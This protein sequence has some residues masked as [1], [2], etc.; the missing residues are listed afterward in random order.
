MLLPCAGGAWSVLRGAGG[1]R[2]FDPDALEAYRADPELQWTPGEALDPTGWERFLAWLQEVL[3]A[4]LGN[5]ASAWVIQHLWVIV[6]VAAVVFLL[7][8]LRGS[9]FVKAIV[10]PPKHAGEVATL[11]EDVAVE[12]I[13]ALIREAEARGEWRRA[14]RLHYLFVLRDLSAAGIIRWRPELTDRDYRQQITD[15][16][17]RAGFATMARTFQWVWYGSVHLDGPT[18]EA[19][20]VPFRQH[21]R[22]S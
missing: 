6:L 8:Y 16:T 12:D 15:P 11:H 18:Y 10:R 5:A 13:P 2:A 9:L 14:L 19:L 4:V 20:I 21:R 17:L 3:R 7:L 22:R 1:D